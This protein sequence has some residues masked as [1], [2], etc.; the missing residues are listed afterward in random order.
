MSID[1]LDS[2]LE[3]M[4]ANDI[5]DVRIYEHLARVNVRRIEMLLA[6]LRKVEAAPSPRGRGA[7]S[8]RSRRSDLKGRV[9]EQV[10][11]VLVDGVKCFDSYSR[12]SSS[13]NEL[14]LLV[15]LGPSATFVPALRSW[16]TH[17]I[18]EC[19]FH[20]TYVQNDWVSKLN[21]VLSTHGA[22]VG[23]LFSRKGI[24]TAGNGARIRSLLQLLANGQQPSFILCLDWID[25]ESCVAGKNFLQ[26]ISERFVEVRTGSRKLSL[27]AS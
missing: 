14:D 8:F 19:K 23:L 11:Q 1:S 9:Y 13:T 12:I 27:V 2:Y 17:C 18:C 24:A 6:R 22:P 20:T 26:L 21:T 5:D 4:T 25:L 7:A 3:Y 16:N 10:V 15:V